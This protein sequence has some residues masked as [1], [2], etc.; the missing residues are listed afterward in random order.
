[1]S[2][3]TDITKE[4][5]EAML[6][7]GLS[8]AEM[9]RR[10]STSAPTIVRALKEFG[11]YQADMSKAYRD[12]VSDGELKVRYSRGESVEALAKAFSINPSSISRRL[13]K[14]GVEVNRT[15][16]K[17]TDVNDDVLKQMYESG[18]NCSQIGTKVGLSYR[19]VSLRLGKIGVKVKVHPWAKDHLPTEEIKKA[20]LD[21]TPSTAL[22]KKYGV[23]YGTI[24]DLLRREGVAIREASYTS[25]GELEIRA[26]L[27]EELGGNFVKTTSVIRGEL[28]LYD[29]ERKLAIEYCGV[30]W[31]S[32]RAGNK[33]GDHSFKQRCCAELGITLLTIFENEWEHQREIVKSILA[34][35]MGKSKVIMARNTQLEEL[36][37][38]QEVAAFFNVNH[39]QGHKGY[40]RAFG[41]RHQGELVMAISFGVPSNPDSRKS[42]DWEIVRI[43]TKLGVSVTG[44]LTKLIAGCGL[45]GSMLSYADL[46]YGNGKSLERAGFELSHIA[47]A[48]YWYVKIGD[49]TNQ[50]HSRLKFQKH[51]LAGLLEIYDATKSEWELMQVNG[52]DRIWDCGNAVWVRD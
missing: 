42:Y 30:Y 48:N 15:P 5:L 36:V 49:K 32:E 17:R 43:A 11:L 10:L 35:K 29:H 19:A 26:F 46:R 25:T 27:N 40:Q 34:N 16:Q 22:A 21:G 1:M 38:R 45:E 39:I 44:G 8:N 50:L 47:P 28:D 6:A 51:K 20:Y 37:D 31:H 3:R 24:L 9:G 23:W 33:R 41:L 14:M 12:D 2:K 52:W 13:K 18:L 7:E 4:T